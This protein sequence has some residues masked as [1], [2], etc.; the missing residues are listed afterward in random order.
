MF[1]GLI[2]HYNLYLLFLVTALNIFLFGSYPSCLRST[3]YI[4][5]CTRN[6]PL[7]ISRSQSVCVACIHYY[8]DR[9]FAKIWVVC[10]IY[11]AEWTC[12]QRYSAISADWLWFSIF[13]KPRWNRGMLSKA[14]IPYSQLGPDVLYEPMK[15][16]CMCV[17]QREAIVQS[18]VWSQ[19]CYTRLWKAADLYIDE[20]I[21]SSWEELNLMRTMLHRNGHSSSNVCNSK[22][23]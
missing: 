22:D 10:K 16:V 6:E 21:K 14:S 4:Y 15:S 19:C 7:K 12:I 8:S 5:A 17:N 3:D 13:H 1:L 11:V 18:S 20:D 23:N 9:H 2:T